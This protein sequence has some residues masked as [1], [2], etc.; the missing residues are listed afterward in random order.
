MFASKMKADEWGKHRIDIWALAL[1]DLQITEKEFTNARRKSLTLSWPP[2]APADFLELG[3]G[4]ITDNYPDMHK[5][6]IDAAHHRWDSEGVLYETAK[7]VG[8]AALREL[9]EVKTYPQWQRHYVEVCKLHSQGLIAKPT[10][11]KVIE[12]KPPEPCSEETADYY[13]NQIRALLA[14]RENVNNK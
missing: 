4:S 9:P 10:P 2:T 13:L 6:Y 5:A 7:R 3:R 1:S 12:V 14:E 11:T 8:L